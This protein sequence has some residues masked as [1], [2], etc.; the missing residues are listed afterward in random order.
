[1]FFWICIIHLSQ[2]HVVCAQETTIVQLQA[3]QLEFLLEDLSRKLQYSLSASASSRRSFLKVRDK[4]V[5][6]VVIIPLIAWYLQVP[7]RMVSLIHQEKHWEDYST[8]GKLANLGQLWNSEIA[9]CLGFL[10]HMKTSLE[11]E[12]T[13]TIIKK[14]NPH[15]YSQ[16]KW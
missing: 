11:R 6:L 15:C 13:L 3:P 1:M 10:Q 8:Q 5:C 16:F 14:V 4:G 2:K 7:N 12:P 9:G